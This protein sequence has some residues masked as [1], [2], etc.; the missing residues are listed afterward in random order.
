MQKA[1][2]PLL[3]ESLAPARHSPAAERN[4]SA[5][6]QALRAHLPSRG[7]ALEIASGTGQHAAVFAAALPGWRWQPSDRQADAFVS[8]A[9]WA[10][11]S[12]ASA[13]ETPVLL[14]VRA[15]PWP[16]TGAPFGRDFDLVYCANMLH[17]APWSCCAGL[18]QGAARHLRAGGMLVVYGPFVE[19][20]VD[21]AESNK[22]FDADLRMRDAD[23]GL[24]DLN[25]VCR[26]ASAAGLTLVARQAMPANNLLLVFAHGNNPAAT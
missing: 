10:R 26:E 25:D 15:A 20:G 3:T 5:I 13:V 14:D 8:I 7:S 11:L 18:M 2:E 19:S 6:L 9:Q 23:W 17:I 16:A 21:T 4:A 1:Q 12:G 24:R 22:A